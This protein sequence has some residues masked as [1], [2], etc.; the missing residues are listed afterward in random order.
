MFCCNSHVGGAVVT[1]DIMGDGEITTSALRAQLALERGVSLAALNIVLQSGR[2]CN[3][4]NIDGPSNF[5]ICSH[6]GCC[7]SA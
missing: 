1:V 5:A 6:E 7:C 3:D 2:V 4:H